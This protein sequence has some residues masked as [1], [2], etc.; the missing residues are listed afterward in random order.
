[1]LRLLVLGYFHNP[2][3]ALYSQKL[4]NIG[5]VKSPAANAHLFD[6]AAP[7]T[8]QLRRANA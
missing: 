4:A 8:K 3:I 5:V 7:T 1:M 2:A 6:T